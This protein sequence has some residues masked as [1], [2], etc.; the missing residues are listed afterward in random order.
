MRGYPQNLK[1]YIYRSK[2]LT[3]VYCRIWQRKQQLTA[4]WNRKCTIND[5]RAVVSETYPFRVT[6]YMYE[7]GNTIKL[8]RSLIIITIKVDDV[9]I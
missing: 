5:F 9:S 3:D 1:L 4:A 6:L 2:G 8:R 7:F